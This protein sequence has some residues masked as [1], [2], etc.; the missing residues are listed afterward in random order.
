MGF[1]SK[2]STIS[3]VIKAESEWEIADFSPQNGNVQVLL[4]KYNVFV[5]SGTI[6]FIN[7]FNKTKRICL[8]LC[9]HVLQR[10]GFFSKNKLQNLAAYWLK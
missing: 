8:K 7:D 4:I 6:S 2:S 9:Q 10:L 1:G 5:K 3:N